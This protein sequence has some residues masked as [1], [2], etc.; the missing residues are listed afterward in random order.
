M[1]QDRDLLSIQEVRDK[2]AKARAAFATIQE[3]SQEQIDRIVKAMADAAYAHAEELAK[4]AVEETGMG[5][6]ED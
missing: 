2:V 1:L 6:W 3:F 5:K 4:M